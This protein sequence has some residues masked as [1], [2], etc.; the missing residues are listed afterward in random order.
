MKKILMVLSLGL[1]ATGA[2]NADCNLVSH[3]D[4]NTRDI[5]NRYGSWAG[6][7][8]EEQQKVKRNCELLAKNNMGVL[9]V[10]E[11]RAFPNVSLATVSLL[12]KD[13]THD[14]ATIDH[15]SAWAMA[16]PQSSEQTAQQL[17]AISI[18]KAFVS[19]DYEGLKKA[20]NKVHSTRNSL[21]A[22]RK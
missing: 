22:N 4:D 18:N 3:M 1:A 19:W 6:S 20:V 15:A 12:V 8:P 13:I 9:V 7:T 16:H 14:V 2:A 10:A 17:L 11:N 5:F 21:R